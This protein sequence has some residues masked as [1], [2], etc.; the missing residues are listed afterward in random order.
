MGSAA[1]PALP[2]VLEELA[3]VRRHDNDDSTGNVRYDVTADAALLGDC[4]AL[5]AAVGG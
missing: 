1:G 4:R 3:S 5:A 2:L